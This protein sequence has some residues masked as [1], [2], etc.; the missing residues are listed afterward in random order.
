[1]SI[2]PF[3]RSGLCPYVELDPENPHFA[4]RP[5]P[6]APVL[7]GMN[8]QNVSLILSQ[9]ISEVDSPNWTP[10][11]EAVQLL[12]EAGLVSLFLFLKIICA[13]SGPYES[14][15]SIHLDLA[16]FCQ[17]DYCMV[18]GS[19][20]VILMGRGNFKS[21][22][23]THGADAW[24]L[25]RWPDLQV[26][27][28]NAIVDKAISFMREIRNIYTVNE[29]VR[30][31][32]PHHCVEN[33]KTQDRWNEKELVMPNRSK[34]APD[35]SI[36]CVGVGGA[37]EGGHA[38]KFDIDDPVGLKDIDSGGKSNLNMEDAKKWFR[39]NSR[40]LVHDWV[41]SRVALKATRYAVDDVVQITMDDCR[42]FVGIQ[43]VE[44]KALLDQVEK[45]GGQW[46]TYYRLGVENGKATFPE[47][48]PLAEL[49]K[50][51][52]EDWWYYITQCVNWPQ[53]TGLAEFY[54]MDVHG[55]E[56][57]YQDEVWWVRKVEDYNFSENENNVG[58]WRKLDDLDV[59]MAIDPAGTDKG[60]S[61][62]T[63]RT[64]IVI[65]ALDSEGIYYLIWS[66]VGYF[67]IHDMY[68]R[69]FD[70]LRKF[71]GSVRCCYVE[72]NA[73][74]KVLAPLLR[75]EMMERGVYASFQP[76]PSTTDKDA[77]IRN[78]LGLPMEKGKVCVVREAGTEFLAEKQIFPQSEYKKDTLDASEKAFSGLVKPFT[79]E[80]REEVEVQDAMFMSERSPITGY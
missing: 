57:D 59:V 50:I 76:I 44:K 47:R 27:I 53:E 4:I 79:V 66:A 9:L 43:D 46:V 21:T 22:V 64:A 56:L 63:S 10:S 5:H 34:T 52:E 26:I 31:L 39:S 42:K 19:K 1:M 3:E 55:A 67:G 37:S 58:P 14:L 13:Q 35:P 77:R 78:T 24:E 2:A 69:I 71:K 74:Q 61:A 16:N 80:E 25:L 6:N 60:M 68:D 48:Y 20:F 70:G 49:Q 51:A 33:P 40:A 36:R 45:P 18:P 32:Y 73:F 65:W 29:L 7:S 28:G 75:T 8:S 11:A 62:K 41:T 30:Q 15:E 72:S 23:G 12:R 54:Q 17:S 38:D